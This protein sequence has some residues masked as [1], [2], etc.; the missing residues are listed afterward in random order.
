MFVLFDNVDFEI[1]RL[2]QRTVACQKRHVL[3]P[4]TNAKIPHKHLKAKLNRLY[5]SQDCSI[6]QFYEKVRKINKSIISAVRMGRYGAEYGLVEIDQ[7]NW[8]FLWIS[9]GSFLRRQ[10]TL[11]TRLGVMGWQDYQ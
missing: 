1:Y 6:N 8:R 7:S 3:T 9:P 2:L 4:T 10:K 11:G 5:T